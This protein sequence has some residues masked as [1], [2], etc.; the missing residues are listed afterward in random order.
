[1][2]IATK[3]STK[4]IAKIKKMP[5]NRIE[6]TTQRKTQQQ[7]QIF[8]LIFYFKKFKHFNTTHTNER[9]SRI[10]FGDVSN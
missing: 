2:T 5:G 7:K 8:K 1:M 9:V 6:T 10:V 3:T 4:I